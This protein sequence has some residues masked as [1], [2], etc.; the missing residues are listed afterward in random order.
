MSD[1]P[2]L[3]SSL[4]QASRPGAEGGREGFWGSGLEAEQSLLRSPVVDG[5]QLVLRP[6]QER[7]APAEIVPGRFCVSGPVS[8]SG[9]RRGGAPEAWA[10][11]FHG[12]RSWVE[13]NPPR[14]TSVWSGETSGRR[15]SLIRARFST[16]CFARYAGC[17]G[18]CRGGSVV[19]LA[20]PV[21]RRDPPL[22]TAPLRFPT[23]AT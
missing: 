21:G 12:S 17:R 19:I 4:K 13:T 14:Q 11:P 22:L 16:S 8:A 23:A 7:T 9:S 5:L 1:H 18:W 10:G 15:A 6:K 20:H 3:G 2:G